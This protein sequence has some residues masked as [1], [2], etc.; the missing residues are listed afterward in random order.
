MATTYTLKAIIPP[1][2]AAK[3]KENGYILCLGKV[4]HDASGN[5]TV[6]VIWN[7]D[8]QF[9]YTNH[10]KWQETYSIAGAVENTVRFL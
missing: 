6:N 1:E 4:V 10:F 9:T 2:Q 8:P 5:P 7:S 3:L